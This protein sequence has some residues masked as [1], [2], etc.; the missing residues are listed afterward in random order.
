[1]N[2][3]IVLL[4]GLALFAGCM[5]GNGVEDDALTNTSEAEFGSE[6]TLCDADNRPEA[7]TREYMPVCGNNNETY[8]NACTACSDESVAAHRP[9]SCDEPVA[10]ACG[11]QELESFF[12]ESVSVVDSNLIEDARV[13][14]PGDAVTM[15][16]RPDRL[17]VYL[18]S[19]D[20]VERVNCG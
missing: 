16:Y 4:M 20:V 15:D 1:M 19:Q 18:D 5:S 7:C 2:K 8:S 14:R 10:D 9:G 6:W 17:N 11:A 12:G 3:M 13:I